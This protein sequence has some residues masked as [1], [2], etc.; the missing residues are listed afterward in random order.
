VLVADEYFILPHVRHGRVAR[1]REPATQKS[2]LFLFAHFPAS[3]HSR[4]T[5][6]S[7]L[8]QFVLFL[9][10]A[11]SAMFGALNPHR[12]ELRD[13]PVAATKPALTRPVP[14]LYKHQILS[15]IP[16]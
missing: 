16:R 6:S 7:H 11:I 4:E 9:F 15:A 13:P 8:R 3:R 10:S 2:A 5:L 14:M 12:E 1:Q